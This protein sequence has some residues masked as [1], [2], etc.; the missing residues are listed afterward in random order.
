[1]LFYLLF[2]LALGLRLPVLRV[3]VPALG[4][5]AVL[6]F[7]RTDSWPA[8]TTLA[9][10][11]VLEFVLGVCVGIA[12][13]RGFTMSLLPASLVMAAAF[14]VLLSV[15]TGP[16][17]GAAHLM[18]PQSLRLLIWGVPAAAIVL[19]AAAC[20]S[21]LGP[22]HPRWLLTLGDASYSIYLT[23]SFVMPVIGIA[24]V[25]LTTSMPVALALSVVLGVAVSAIGGV[26]AYRLVERPLVEALRSRAGEAKA[27]A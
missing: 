8:I 6:S 21:R 2:A 15:G 25:R 27:I 20:E 17:L 9:D 11:L 26:L 10:T 12:V 16:V 5:L 4:L 18:A 19:S 14:A 13:L 22:L 23:H 24:V 7:V 3:L 1:M